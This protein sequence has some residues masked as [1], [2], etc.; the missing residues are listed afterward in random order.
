M[1]LDRKD[2]FLTVEPGM[3]RCMWFRGVQREGLDEL[4]IRTASGPSIGFGHLSRAL[5]LA[6]LARNSTMTRFLVD[7]DDVWTRERVRLRGW[8]VLAFFPEVY[9]GADRQP[10]CLLIDTRD[11]AGLEPLIDHA[12]RQKIPV[13]SIHDLGLSPLPSDVVVDGSIRPVSQDPGTTCRMGPSYLVLDP[14]FGHLHDQNRKLRHR[15]ETV[16][17]SLGGG[18]TGQYFTVLIEGLQQWGRQIRVIGVPGFVE[19]GQ[20]KL[21]ERS[22][23][24]VRFSWAMPDEPL[25]RLLAESDLALTAGGLSAYESLCVG[26]PACCLA[27]DRHQLITVHALAE[28]GACVNLGLGSDLDASLLT[29]WLDA[30]DQNP[31]ERRAMMKRGKELIDG[32]GA[33]RVAALLDSIMRGTAAGARCRRSLP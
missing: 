12:R 14:L 22:W 31:D 18:D 25:P 9:C 16:V 11:T 15:I 24:P 26:T 4:W 13:V 30:L 23:A 8:E 19:W 32:R 6:E 7:P 17:V 29:G 5:I 3:G 28:A 10:D 33:A 21:S 27:L 1:R 20:R 2:K